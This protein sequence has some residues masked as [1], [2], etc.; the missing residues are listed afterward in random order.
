[1][2]LITF[3]VRCP[4]HVSDPCVYRGLECGHLTS[5][6]RAEV[7]CCC[8]PWSWRWYSSGREIRHAPVL[9]RVA[10]QLDTPWKPQQPG[11]GT[12]RRQWHS[13]SLVLSAGSS[14]TD[15]QECNIRQ[16]DTPARATS[17]VVNSGPLLTHGR[18]G[19]LNT[20]VGDTFGAP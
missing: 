12:S 10:F 19:A 18:H 9:L 2:A 20:P 5:R 7:F 3:G 4:Q 14:T 17:F 8:L 11:V 13:P 1:M 15:R 6:G 16:Q